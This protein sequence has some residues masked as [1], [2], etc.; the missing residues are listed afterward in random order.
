M[1]HL[2]GPFVSG[3]HRPSRAVTH[4]LAA[5][6]L[7]ALVGV[8]GLATAIAQADDGWSAEDGS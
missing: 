4:L 8:L 3:R 1:I 2:S 7:F 5:G 6:L